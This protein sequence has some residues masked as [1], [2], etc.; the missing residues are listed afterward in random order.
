M[1]SID[2][3]VQALRGALAGRSEVRLALLFGSTARG[4]ATE[5]SDV[6]VAV[7]APGACLLE[8]AHE[9]SRAVGRDVD[10]ISLEYPGVPML[11]QLVRDSVVVYEGTRGAAANWRSATLLGLELDRPWYRRMRD[12]WLRRVAERGV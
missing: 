8:L 4:E 11:E 2:D 12:A 9:L 5:S 10:V 6:D 3:I 7:L 1:E